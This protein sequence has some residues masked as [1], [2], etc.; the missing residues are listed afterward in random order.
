[1]HEP[2]ESEPHD[3]ELRFRGRPLLV[4]TKALTRSASIECNRAI[5]S[6]VSTL[7]KWH[8][9]LFLLEGQRSEAI[10]CA[11]ATKGCLEVQSGI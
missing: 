9:F 6:D 4:K 2:S 8:A 3:R 7:L 1:M 11:S 5:V 10:C